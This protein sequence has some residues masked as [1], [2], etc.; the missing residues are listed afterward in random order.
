MLG[1][2]E[3]YEKMEFET[4]LLSCND[5]LQLIVTQPISMGVNVTRQV[6]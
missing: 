4:R 3:H 6:T 1:K 5:H 2:H